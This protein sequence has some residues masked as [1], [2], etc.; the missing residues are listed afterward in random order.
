MKRKSLYLVILSFLIFIPFISHSNAQTYKVER[1]IDGDTLRLT[2]GEK[3]RLIGID[4]PESKPNPR[5]EKQGEREGKDLKT[6]LSMGKESSKFVRSLVKP[7]DQVGIEFDVEKRDR[8]RRLLGYLYLSNGRMLN[9]EI[10]RAGYAN[11]LTHPP[12]VKY[13]KRFLSAYREARENK[14][15]LWK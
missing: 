8:Y 12:N 11:L 5:A 15:G 7:G 3:V 4:A 1:V 14:R 2:N 6:I 9:E 13:Q 10:V